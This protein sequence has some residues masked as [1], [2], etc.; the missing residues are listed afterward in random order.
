M[1]LD[2]SPAEQ[3][4]LNYN[5]RDVLQRQ[6][7]LLHPGKHGPGENGWEP[8]PAVAAPQQLHLSADSPCRLVQLI[9][10][11]HALEVN[12]WGRGFCANPRMQIYRWQK[13]NLQNT[14][15]KFHFIHSNLPHSS[16]QQNPYNYN[17]FKQGV[18]E[19]LFLF[20]ISAICQ[21]ETHVQNLCL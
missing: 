21:Y 19:L 20:L 17:W 9:S 1:C 7:Q 3:Q 12:L 2:W 4:D 15:L 8:H 14:V 6:H 10:P 11:K 16:R 13:Y 5:R 18:K